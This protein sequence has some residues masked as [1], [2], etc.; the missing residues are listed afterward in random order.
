MNNPGGEQDQDGIRERIPLSLLFSTHRFV[1]NGANLWAD[2][3]KTG[4]V[5]ERGLS[6]AFAAQAQEFHSPLTSGTAPDEAGDSPE[7]TPHQYQQGLTLAPFR[8]VPVLISQ[9]FH[10]PLVRLGTVVATLA[11]RLQLLQPVHIQR[12]Q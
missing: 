12:L 1:P 8:F 6:Q 11:E 4:T 10:V 9:P 5:P 2:I 3:S 7:F